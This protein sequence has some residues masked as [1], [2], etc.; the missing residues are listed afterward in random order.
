MQD[1]LFDT[2]RNAKTN[3]A[4]EGSYGY[5][6]F[7]PP[8]TQSMSRVT[9]VQNPPKSPQGYPGFQHF[10]RSPRPRTECTLVELF[11]QGGRERSP[12]ISSDELRHE[13]PSLFRLLLITRPDGV[14]SI[15]HTSCDKKFEKILRNLQLT[16][17]DHCF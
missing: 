3:K 11:A 5:P 13:G 17:Y 10:L 6:R 15:P 8:L 2:G 12:G 7:L 4:S 1:I 16:G 9:S 14:E